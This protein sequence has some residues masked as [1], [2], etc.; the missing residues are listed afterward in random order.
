MRNLR[1]ALLCLSSLV[2]R[3]DSPLTIASP[4]PAR[5]DLSPGNSEVLLPVDTRDPTQMEQARVAMSGFVAP[6]RNLSA[7]RLHLPVE[8]HPERL[9]LGVCQAL[10]AQNPEQKIYLE[11]DPALPP[12]WDETIWGALDGGALLPD[13]LGLDPARWEERLTRA[14]EILPGRPWSLWL[15]SDPGP[16]ASILLGDGARLV[17]PAGGAAAKLALQIPAE[18]TEVEGGRG[19]LTLRRPGTNDAKRWR[20]IGNTWIAESLSPDRKEVAV[21]AQ[22]SYDVGALLAKVRATTLRDRLALRQFEASLAVDLHIQEFDGPGIDLGYRFRYFH[23]AGEQ[24]EILQKEVLFNGVRANLKGEAHLPVIEARTTSALPV[25]LALTERYRYQDGGPGPRPGSRHITF[26][27]A[28]KD[29]NLYAGQLLVEEA[30]G[31]ILEEKS[32]REGLPGIVKSEARTLTYGAPSPGLWTLQAL[33][34]YDRWFLGN[35]IVQVRRTWTLSGFQVNQ[36]TFEAA[37]QAARTS[38]AT[39]MIQTPEG[40]RYYTRQPNGSRKQDDRSRT[41]GRAVGAFLLIDPTSELP[42]LPFA[43]ALFYDFD[44]F[45][46]GIQYTFLTAILFNTGSLSLPNLFGGFDFQGNLTL[47]VPKSTDRPVRDGKLLEQEAVG[48]RTERMGLSLGHDLGLGF[49][50]T[51]NQDVAWNHYS[52]APEAKYRSPDFLLPQS[53]IDHLTTGVLGWQGRGFLLQA[54]YGLGHRSEERYGLPGAITTEVDGGRYRQWSGKAAYSF[55]LGGGQ[56][57]DVGLGQMGGTGFDRFRSIGSSGLGGNGM[58]TG[59]RSDAIAADRKGYGRLGYVLPTGPNLRLTFQVEHARMRSLDDQK[60]YGFTGLGLS[61]AM[62]GFWWFT[63][64]RMDLGFGLQ[65]DIPGLRTVNG[66]VTFLRVF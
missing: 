52:L 45:G 31:R 41:S 19:E 16:L 36:E 32:H 34:S 40:L 66:M 47:I 28:D 1:P 54:T 64:C 4:Q 20:L 18:Y 50:F 11:F 63:T 24:E 29:G 5:F 46:K 10:K 21:I 65:T 60:T 17:V 27:P 33:K 6:Y 49:R 30:T 23:H 44:A 9:L 62:P 59:L 25:A 22:A 56:R 53:G 7:I 15:P 14:Q 37:R 55:D 42:V 57:L 38:Q 3:A 26:M 35:E 12:L 2:V 58:P 8:G 61:G 51:L 39:M 13:Q 48:R 43:A